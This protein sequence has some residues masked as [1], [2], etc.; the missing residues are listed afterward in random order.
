MK[1][2]RVILVPV[3]L[4]L[5]AAL[6]LACVPLAALETV[7]VTRAPWWRLPYQSMGIWSLAVLLICFPL[8]VWLMRGKRWAIFVTQGF[9]CAWV[10]LNVSIA[11][12]LRNPAIGFFTLLLLAF[13]GA[14][15]VWIRHEMGRSFFD[16]QLSWYQGL[17]RPLP[18]LRCKVS[19]G[20]Q[21]LECRVSRLDREGAF[22]FHES[23]G[24]DIGAPGPLSSLRPEVRSELTF[25]FRERTIRFPALPVRAL[26]GDRG[27]GF[28]FNGLAPDHRKQLG[29]FIETLKGEGYV[30]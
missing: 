20:D 23:R 21:E 24:A 10:L 28:Q 1:S 17:P 8:A 2:M 18:G 25:H 13:F 15:S 14:L 6:L 3:R 26:D 7:I 29:D 4:R 12:R 11:I 9:F 16:P 27:V 19:W 30:L 5:A 22:V